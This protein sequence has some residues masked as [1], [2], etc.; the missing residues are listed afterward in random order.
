MDV[1]LDDPDWPRFSLAVDEEGRLRLVV[2]RGDGGGVHMTWE[3]HVR[4]KVADA[5]GWMGSVEGAASKARSAAS[6]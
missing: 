5:A 6:A 4:L 2:S 1:R 3:M